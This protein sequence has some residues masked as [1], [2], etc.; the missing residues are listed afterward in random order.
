MYEE[1]RILGTCLKFQGSE[2]VCFLFSFQ[3]L[4]MI[5][6]CVIRMVEGMIWEEGG[7]FI[8]VRTES[9]Q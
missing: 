8:L 5:I 2:I 7:S 4:A 1:I 6:V 9:H 3:S